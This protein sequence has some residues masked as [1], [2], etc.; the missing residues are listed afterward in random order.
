VCSRGGATTVSHRL[1]RGFDGGDLSHSRAW[2]GGRAVQGELSTFLSL[3]DCGQGDLR[4]GLAAAVV[5]SN[6][7]CRAGSNGSRGGSL[8]AVESTGQGRAAA[9]PRTVVTQ[10]ERRGLLCLCPVRKVHGMYST[11]SC[12]TQYLKVSECHN[13]ILPE[14]VDRRH[15]LPRLPLGGS[16]MCSAVLPSALC[17]QRLGGFNER[18]WT[19]QAVRTT[20]PPAS[21]TTCHISSTSK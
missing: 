21:M 10:A 17:S 8:C 4:R 3:L 9:P 11:T 5:G 19:A 2:L 13:S 20:Y 6:A 15:C 16:R 18:H 14:I 12:T 7:C 1:A